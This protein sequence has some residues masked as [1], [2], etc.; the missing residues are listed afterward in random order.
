MP[1]FNSSTWRKEKE[2]RN[3]NT[4]PEKNVNKRPPASWLVAHENNTKEIRRKRRQV[5][6][7]RTRV[8]LI[9]YQ[10]SPHGAG[11][12]SQRNDMSR[13]MAI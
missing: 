12:P 7:M 1:F 10:Y 6:S 2:D 8:Y 13:S 5:T 11:H 3:N 4:K 9:V